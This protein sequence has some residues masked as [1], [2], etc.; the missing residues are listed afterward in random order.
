MPEEFPTHT[1]KLV[2][3]FN[4]TAYA[5]WQRQKNAVTLQQIVEE[6]LRNLFH[7]EKL[8]VIGCGRT[9]A[10]VHALGMT[11]SFRIDASIPAAELSA[12]LNKRF[13]HDIRL[14]SAEETDPRFNAH[15]SNHGKAYVYAVNLG[16][17]NLFLTDACWSWTEA[18][19]MDHVKA[20]VPMMLG[21]HD[22]LNFTGRKADIS[23]TVRT[24]YRAE[25]VEF[26]PVVCF[27]FSG[28]GFLHKMVR[29]LMG[30]FHNIAL[31]NLTEENFA[32]AMKFPDYN[33]CEEVAPAQGLYLKKVF[34]EPDGWKTDRLE[35]PP[36]FF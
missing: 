7:R 27:Y 28:N 20:A 36:F 15:F 21:E 22:F 26:G 5:G 34:Y 29:R 1:Y 30:F 9:D 16:Y 10:G 6:V 35:F 23:S 18:P 31:G 17:E 25:L 4:G 12:A 13:P 3:A 19:H 8:C 11:V 14:V 32:E 2:L 24:I 33:V